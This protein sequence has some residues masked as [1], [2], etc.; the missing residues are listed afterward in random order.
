MSDSDKSQKLKL[1]A[2]WHPPGMHAAGWRMPAAI[3]G[4]EVKFEHYL[5]VVRA[6]ERV[7][8]CAKTSACLSRRVGTPSRPKPEYH[9]PV[10]RWPHGSWFAASGSLNHQSSGYATASPLPWFVPCPPDAQQS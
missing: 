1:T 5:H 7:R 6:L 2:F 9:C 10:S 8:R 4:T 3:Q